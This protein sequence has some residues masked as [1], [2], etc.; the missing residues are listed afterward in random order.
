M[1]NPVPARFTF[2][3]R[4]LDAHSPSGDTWIESYPDRRN[5]RFEVG[6]A[7]GTVLI[8]VPERLS[9]PTGKPWPDEADAPVEIAAIVA[10]V[11]GR[12]DPQGTDKTL[13]ALREEAV[14]RA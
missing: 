11:I 3:G 12:A 7:G 4:P 2:L 6:D 5:P 14:D 8:S 9:E 10:E 1:T 13:Q